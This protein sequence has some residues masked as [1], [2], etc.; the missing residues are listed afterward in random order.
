MEDTKHLVRRYIEDVWNRGDVTALDELTSAVFAYHLNGQPSL[1]RAGMRSF[2]SMMRAAFPDWHV[3]ISEMIAEGDVVAVRWRGKA[4]HQ[5]A[6][7]GIPPT[8]RPISVTGIN[9]YYL[10]DGT[11]DAEWEQMDSLGMAQQLGALQPA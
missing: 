8:G 4:T 10:A 11:V 3:E 7:R 2:I 6:F 1:D 5:G 9:M